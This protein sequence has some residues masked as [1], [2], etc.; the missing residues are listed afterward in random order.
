MIDLHTHILPG[1]DDGAKTFE[2]SLA[3]LRLEADSG[4]KTVALTP[5][6]D[7]EKT[8]PC[9]FLDNLKIK[10]AQL[11]QLVSGQ[12]FS[13]NL[14]SAAEVRLSPSIPENPFI[15]DFCYPG[16]HYLL[17]EL[18]FEY[19]FNWIPNTLFQ[20]NR[21]GITPILAHIERYQY[22]QERPQL[23]EELIGAGAAAQINADSLIS[24]SRF[25]QRF[26]LDMIRKNTVHLLVSDT[27]SIESRPPRL[28]IAMEI[29][30]EKLGVDAVEY[31]CKNAEAV[32]ENRNLSRNH[33]LKI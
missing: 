33:A 1:I 6:F 30:S 18:P 28:K 14:L 10:C 29:I 21:L 7:F 24:G 4:I 22:F 15:E 13:V 27:H 12:D 2:Q 32:V 31:L 3:L 16:T 26:V 23:L 9:A 8:D 17:V 11:Q 20:C 5:H 25:L 19:F